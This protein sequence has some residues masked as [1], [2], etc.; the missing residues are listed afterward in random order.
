MKALNLITMLLLIIGGIDLGLLGLFG[1]DLL[2]LVFGFSP[3]LLRI[4]YI[5]IGLSALWQIMP[6]TRTMQAGIA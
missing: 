1:W 5:I 3:I 4:V 2:T 6:L